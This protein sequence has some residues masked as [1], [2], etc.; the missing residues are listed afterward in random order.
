M[1]EGNWQPSTYQAHEFQWNW[2]ATKKEG[3][4]EERERRERREGI[5][6]G[7]R[8]TFSILKKDSSEVVVIAI[9]VLGQKKIK[10][11]IRT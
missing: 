7:R 11:Y 3:K 8:I 2:F 5:R 4:R 1:I 9:Y 6:G 10:E